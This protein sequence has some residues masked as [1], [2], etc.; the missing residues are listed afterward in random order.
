MNVEDKKKL[1]YAYEVSSS[2]VL[3]IIL[4]GSFYPHQTPLCDSPVFL[5][6]SSVLRSTCPRYITYQELFE[7]KKLFMRGNVIL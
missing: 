2:I 4:F 1:K 3:I 6:P 5:H 7:T